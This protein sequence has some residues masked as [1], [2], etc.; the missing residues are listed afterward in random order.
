MAEAGSGHGA[1][2]FVTYRHHLDVYARARSAGLSDDAYLALVAEAD[3]AVA[4]V[5]GAGFTTTPLVDLT[6][7]LGTDP[8]IGGG[9][10]VAKVETGGVAGSHKARHLF[11]LLLHI[12]I[13]G[14]QGPD[15]PPLAIASCGNAALAAAVVARAAERRLL[16]HVPVDAD[17]AVLDRLDDLEAEVTVCRRVAG[18]EGDPCIH[19]L[20]A[21]IHEGAVPF[22]VQGTKAAASIDGGRTLGLELADQLADRALTPDRIYIQIGGGAL[23]TATMDGLARAGTLDRLPALHPVQAAS[24]HPY[25]SAW[26]RLAPA[27]FAGLGA[28]DPGADPL[29][30][31]ILARRAGELD[32]D[33]LAA[34]HP[35]A[36]VPWPGTPASV[37][38]GIL[39][40]V[41]YDWAMV[42]AH[43]IRTGG[44]PILVDEA[45]FVEAARLAAGA[46][47]VP[48]PDETG[49]AA[50][51]GLLT[52]RRDDPAARPGLAVVLL[53]GVR[54]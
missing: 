13:D 39:D 36:M 43:Q 2:P 15:G 42:A 14:P 12:G 1:N 24:A 16:V 19:A 34:D 5:D 40:D 8:L 30:A 53:T 44:W 33:S 45:T 28:T 29:R 20:D 3:D 32:L 6:A 9:P 51:A 49:A 35:E 47:V 7:T 50:L 18:I 23:A 26:E 41:T 25:A 31:P 11:G 46:G 4:D 10:V 38:S 37:A 22:T 48:P 27:L 52:H 21:A 17:T 54:R